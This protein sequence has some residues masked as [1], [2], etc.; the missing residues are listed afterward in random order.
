[1]RFMRSTSCSCA[2]ALATNTV[3]AI[4]KNDTPSRQ[5]L[6]SPTRSA[7]VGTLFAF[8]FHGDLL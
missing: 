1:M 5:R 2:W 6:V 7:R 3:L 4:R 8:R